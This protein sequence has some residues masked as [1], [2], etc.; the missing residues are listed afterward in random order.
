MC[1]VANPPPNPAEGEPVEGEPAVE[2]R[3][4]EKENP[5]DFLRAPDEEGGVLG[6]RGIEKGLEKR[7]KEE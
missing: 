6:S 2:L 3:E 1:T 7:R 4:G 5:G